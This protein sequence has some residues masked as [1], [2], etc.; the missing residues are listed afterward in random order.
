VA[1]AALQ[2]SR[3]PVN[4]APMTSPRGGASCMPPAHEID[5]GWAVD[6]TWMGGSRAEGRG[7]R[8]G[9]MATAAHTDLG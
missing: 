7:A 4:N 9:S 6:S 5:K 2:I 1:S 8:R 3:R